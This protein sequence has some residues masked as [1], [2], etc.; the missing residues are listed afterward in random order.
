LEEPAA[1]DRAGAV[2]SAE[3][4]A[5]ERLFERHVRPELPA[6]EERR[7][8]LAGAVWISVVLLALLAAVAAAWLGVRMG[9]APV[10]IVAAAALAV[11]IQVHRRQERLWR[12]ALL[13]RLTRALAAG[14]GEIRHSEH[15]GAGL[16][17]Q[18]EA[19]GLLAPAP[20]RRVFHRI[21]G[22][23]Q[24]L[25]FVALYAARARSGRVACLV[26]S[27]EVPAAPP[28]RVVVLPHGADA[29]PSLQPVAFSDAGF[30]SRFVVLTTAD[31]ADL[32]D[33]VRS[34]LVPSLRAA[35]IALDHS[36][37]RSGVLRAAFD[38]GSFILTLPLPR[39][40]GTGFLDG[41]GVLVLSDMEAL[42]RRVAGDLALPH[43]IVDRLVG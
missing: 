33:A 19:L 41:G 15:G 4:A 36:A 39:H 2:P 14:L 16:L 34:Y 42:A 18:A 23:R 32:A 13:D 30:A 21:E 6:L 40:A 28:A 12:R 1:V 24:G 38:G 35:L 10:P 25:R 5:F 17:E 31:G 7:H 43:R 20:R 3:E 9:P 27:V 22:D 37:G 11:G 26:L 29:D 8:R